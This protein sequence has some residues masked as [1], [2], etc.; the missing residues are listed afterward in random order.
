MRWN[1]IQL[2]QEFKK[3]SKEADAFL[4]RTSLRDGYM[5]FPIYIEDVEKIYDDYDNDDITINPNLLD[6]LNRKSYYIPKN[7]SLKLE[8]YTPHMSEREKARTI[9]NIRMHYTIIADETFYSM[10]KRSI[11]DTALTLFAALLLIFSFKLE[12]DNPLSSQMINIFAWVALWTAVADILFEYV[13]DIKRRKHAL[14]LRDALYVFKP[15]GEMIRREKL[16]DSI[17]E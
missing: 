7:Y 2:F 1:I 8:F 4:E 5:V 14:Q 16:E 10:F 9:E 17:T 15:L 12:K 13:S 6:F 11:K 3:D